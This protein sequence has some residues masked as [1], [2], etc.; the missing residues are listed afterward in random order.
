MRIAIVGGGIGG[1][2]AGLA[3]RLCG[4]DAHVYER[5]KAMTEVGAGL[6]LFANGVRALERLGLGEALQAQGTRSDRAAIFRPN[7]S[8]LLDLKLETLGTR[9]GTATLGIHRAELQRLL[10]AQLPPHALHLNAP[11]IGMTRLGDRILVRFADG[12]QAEADGVVGAD[13]LH[14]IIR[15]QL[16]GSKRPR[17][18][19]YTAWR[20]VASVDAGRVTHG[21]RFI[22]GERF[23][24]GETWGRGMRFGV[25]PLGRGQVYW[26][27]TLNAPAG[28][29]SADGEKAELL[30]RFGHWHDPI[31]ALLK[32]TP[33]A[34]ILRNDIYDR[35]PLRTW[36]EGAVTLLG[37]AAH[38]MTPNLGQGANQALEDALVLADV[39]AA[40][41]DPAEGFR[42]Y[43][44][45]RLARTRA[46]VLASRRFGTVA[47]W[48]NPFSVALRNGLIR[49]AP[50]RYRLRPLEHVLKGDPFYQPG[51]EA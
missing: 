38:P 13:G 25:L 6:S 1:L 9:F 3:L 5:A 22:P 19:G 46:I 20:G 24:P 31:P 27:A 40:L 47:Q 37:D 32:A 8:R 30:R 10:L 45:R 39:L 29:R 16:H 41:P 4:V 12:S 48:Q 42:A 34:A 33:A 23:V 15:A 36:G 35:D 43:E 49:R 17:Y 50:P 26:F 28:G 7:G 11:C 51:D 44:Q 14:S 18:A 2:A 21:E